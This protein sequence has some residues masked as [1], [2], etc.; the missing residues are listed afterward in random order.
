LDVV[1]TSSG[2]VVGGKAFVLLAENAPFI[3]HLLDEEGEDNPVGGKCCVHD[4]MIWMGRHS[5]C[6]G[7]VNWKLRRLI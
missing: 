6:R 3:L 7:R 1:K 2:A 5:R 4:Y